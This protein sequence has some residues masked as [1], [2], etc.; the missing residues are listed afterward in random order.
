[1]TSNHNVLLLSIRK[2][3]HMFVIGCGFQGGNYVCVGNYPFL[4]LLKLVNMN[5]NLESFSVQWVGV[6]KSMAV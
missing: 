1:M 6:R 3:Q 5:F 2:Y 4:S